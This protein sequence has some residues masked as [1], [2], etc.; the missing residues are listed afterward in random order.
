MLSTK[1]PY[2]RPPA[3]HWTSQGALALPSTMRIE[4]GAHGA[5]LKTF[6]AVLSRHGGRPD[7]ESIS[8]RERVTRI[9]SG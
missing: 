4:S 6:D 1:R 8:T 3:I 9:E 2:S 5:M 7:G